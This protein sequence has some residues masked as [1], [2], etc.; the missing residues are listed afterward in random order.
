MIKGGQK[1][2][3]RVVKHFKSFKGLCNLRGVQGLI[4]Q[5]PKQPHLVQPALSW[6]LDLM[7]SASPFQ[8]KL[9]YDL[10]TEYI[11][12]FS[13]LFIYSNSNRS[14]KTKKTLEIMKVII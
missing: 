13:P 1:I 10:I 6:S 11:T 3:V 7:T 4:R 2:T 5:V 14:L 8:P 12:R 9:F